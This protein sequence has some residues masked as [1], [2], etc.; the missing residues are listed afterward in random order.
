MCACEGRSSDVQPLSLFCLIFWSAHTQWLSTDVTDLLVCYTALTGIGEQLLPGRAP[1][2]FCVSRWRCEACSEYV[3]VCV[4]MRARRSS[5]LCRWAYYRVCAR[6]CVRQRTEYEHIHGVVKMTALL[7]SAGYLDAYLATSLDADATLT[8]LH[9][10]QTILHAI[11]DVLDGS[12]ERVPLTQRPSSN[13]N[14]DVV[15]P[16]LGSAGVALQ[17]DDG[18]RSCPA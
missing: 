11:L 17:R 7:V 6:V 2:E 12:V 4:P 18:I 14:P 15:Q 5:R 9:D 3:R 8:Y 1:T 10:L 16:G 13:G